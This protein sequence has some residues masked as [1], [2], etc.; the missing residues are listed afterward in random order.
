MKSEFDKIA[1]KFGV[2][3]SEKGKKIKVPFCMDKDIYKLIVNHYH[4]VCQINNN[5][6]YFVN[7]ILELVKEKSS[8]E[9]IKEVVD[10]SHTSLNEH[11]EQSFVESE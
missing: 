10:L 9:F 4:E 8:Y 2:E 6:N 5:C 7:K 1:E 11:H 3:F